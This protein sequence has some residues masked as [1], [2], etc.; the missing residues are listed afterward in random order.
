M[1]RNFA[2]ISILVFLTAC[3][4]KFSR[5]GPPPNIKALLQPTRIEGKYSSS[6]ALMRDPSS[7]TGDAQ[8]FMLQAESAVNRSNVDKALLME[9]FYP[10]TPPKCPWYKFG[11]CK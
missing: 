7:T 1:I 9:F 4:A 6:E 5:P 3:A 8:D 2:L 10:P 11:T